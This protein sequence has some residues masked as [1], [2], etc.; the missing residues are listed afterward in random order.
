MKKKQV[1]IEMKDEEIAHLQEQVAKTV[2]NFN[3]FFKS[4]DI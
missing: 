4:N 3:D 1:A 2:S